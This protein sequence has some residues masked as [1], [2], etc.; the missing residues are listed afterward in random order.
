VTDTTRNLIDLAARRLF[1]GGLDKMAHRLVLTDSDG[2]GH[3]GWAIEPL[4]DVLADT[5]GKRIEEL[6][7]LL[8]AICNRCGQQC[9]ILTANAER[10]PS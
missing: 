8:L 2:R 9:E 3:C 10:R 5:L 7:T 1:A 4:K 6:E